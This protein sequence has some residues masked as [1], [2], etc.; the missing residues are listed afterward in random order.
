MNDSRV[1]TYGCAALALFTIT[2]LQLLASLGTSHWSVT[3][4]VVGTKSLSVGAGPAM[5]VA[6]TLAR[7]T[8]PYL[9]RSFDY[10][11]DE[12]G[13]KSSFYAFM[14]KAKYLVNWQRVTI[15]IGFGGG[16]A[17]LVYNPLVAVVL[18]T[19]VLAFASAAGRFGRSVLGGVMG[20]FLGATIC[21]T[22][23][24]ILAFLL[25]VQT[26]NQQQ[27]GFWEQSLSYVQVQCSTL[28]TISVQSMLLSAIHTVWQDDALVRFLLFIGLRKAWMTYVKRA[29]PHKDENTLA[30][31]VHSGNDQGDASE[32]SSNGDSVLQDTPK[33]KAVLILEMPS[34]TFRERYDAVQNYLDVLAKPVGSLGTLESWAARL[35]ALQRTLQPSTVNVACLIFAGDHGVAAAPE[36]GGEGCSAYPQ[37]VTRSVLVGLH[38]G[39]AGASVLAKANNV[40]LRVVDV[41][42]ILGNDNPFQNS[43]YVFS[44]HQKLAKGTRNFC[45]EPAL[46]AEECERC[47]TMGRNSLVEFLEETCSTVVIIGEVGIGNTTSASALLAALTGEPTDAVCGG[48]AF[49]MREVSKDVVAKKISIV[50]KALANHFG[51]N[52]NQRTNSRAADSLAKLGGTEIA[53][54]VGAMLEASNKDIAVLVDGFIATVAALAAVAISPNVCH[55]LF[56]ASHSAEPG[57][58]VAIEAIR[59]I[60]SENKIPMDECPVLSMNLRMGEATAGL[61]AVP[62][63]RCAA[64]VLSDMA[65]IQE[66]LS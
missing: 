1:G 11:D 58:R 6:H 33:S 41:G 26:Q 19:V 22:E 29:A 39:V 61:L 24:L 21:L 65:S 15:A 5:M 14:V 53:A 52:W 2:K 64:K 30:S 16:L 38:R 34:S 63:L 57:Q 3:L 25:V 55:A 40:S 45:L 48:G 51:S 37:T 8:S 59:A 49:A 12:Q 28:D 60:A 46:S 66:I 13:P 17:A 23:L 4:Q 31:G 36:A 7:I 43:K 35:S 20:D 62:I 32:H 47:M 50:D 10:V 9:I 27:G 54:A 44:S 56:F 42:V 18:V